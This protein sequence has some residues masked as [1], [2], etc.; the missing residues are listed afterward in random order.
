MEGLSRFTGKSAC[1]FTTKS[2]TVNDERVDNSGR[3]A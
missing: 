2:L 1:Q 3:L